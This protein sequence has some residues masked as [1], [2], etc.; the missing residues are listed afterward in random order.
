MFS[1]YRTPQL[2][3]RISDEC[4]KTWLALQYDLRGRRVAWYCIIELPTLHLPTQL[5]LRAKR[6]REME[7]KAEAQV[8]CV[9]Y[10]HVDVVS[11]IASRPSLRFP[12]DLCRVAQGGGPG[13]F[14]VVR[15][16]GP[17]RIL[18]DRVG[19][20]GIARWR[21]GDIAAGVLLQAS[22][23]LQSLL[24]SLSLSLSL[25][26]ARGSPARIPWSESL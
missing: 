18:L 19:L 26:G 1:A 23:N 5:I 22:I 4:R 2:I 16:T 10:G 15:I 12:R 8:H 6:L 24:L 7:R 20:R 21:L 9:H 17:I 11:V 3:H 14:R 13:I 25:F